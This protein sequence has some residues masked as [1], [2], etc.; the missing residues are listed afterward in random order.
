MSTK[1]ASRIIVIGGSAG[2][3][4][5]ILTILP[6]LKLQ[7]TVALIIIFHRKNTDGSPLMELLNLKSK[8]PAKEAEDK[9]PIIAQNI[10]VAP[11]DYH[12]LIEN[13]FTFSLD[14]SEKVNYSRPSIDV[15][16]ECVA[17]VYGSNSIAALLSGANNDGSKGMLEIKNAGGVTLVQDPFSAEVD[18]MPKSA[19]N[20]FKPTA[21]LDTFQ[22]IEY[23]N[24]IE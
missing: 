14:F 22:L 20:L 10:Y 2:S 19:L 11:P 13:N 6:K 3:L 21:V 15:T 12:L 9:E 17:D 18:Y 1:I 24:N 8:F 4:E 7:D 5:V 16:F 23:L